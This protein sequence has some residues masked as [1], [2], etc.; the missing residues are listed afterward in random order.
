MVVKIFNYFY[1]S[2]GLLRNFKFL[3]M[4]TI[5]N[6]P[7][8]NIWNRTPLLSLLI[9]LAMVFTACYDTTEDIP[10]PLANTEI[11]AEQRCINDCSQCPQQN[12]CCVIE[13]V[14]G[15]EIIFELCGNFIGCGFDPSCGPIN[16]PAP[17]GTISGVSAGTGPLQQFATYFFCISGNEDIYIFN[18]DQF[19]TARIKVTCTILDTV[20]IFTTLEIEPLRGAFLQI[21]GDCLTSECD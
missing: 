11:E 15:D 5:T 2:V 9:A 13:L 4:N 19:E 18:S 16:A 1:V 10:E 21:D 12:C 3:T 6:Q 20:P 8:N 17:C 14:S 7:R